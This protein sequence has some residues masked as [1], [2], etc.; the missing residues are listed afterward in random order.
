MFEQAII[1]LRSK[2]AEIEETQMSA[3]DAG[4]A[5]EVFKRADHM[6]LAAT[7]LESM[8]FKDTDGDVSLAIKA[9]MGA[10]SFALNQAEV[11]VVP[12]VA[13]PG[14]RI[15]ENDKNV[16]GELSVKVADCLSF[17][18]LPPGVKSLNDLLPP[19]VQADLQLM[20]NRA[21]LVSLLQCEAISAP[22]PEKA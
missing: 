17:V 5:S 8:P 22:E 7:L 6:R 12:L 14:S 13:V 4:D 15:T 18:F 11:A 20:F 9:V 3:A 10:T 19:T 16:L 2:A 21:V 1:E